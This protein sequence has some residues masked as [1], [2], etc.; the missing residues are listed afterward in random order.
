MIM[1]RFLHLFFTLIA[2]VISFE[3]FGQCPPVAGGISGADSICFGETITLTS[4][5]ASMPG[6]WVSDDITIANVTD[7]GAVSGTSAFP[8][9]VII[10]YVVASGCGS[11]SAMHTVYIKR[12]PFP[13]T[14]TGPATVCNGST[15]SLAGV[16][17]GGVW[18]SDNNT[19]AT[20][21][22]TGVVG[23]AAF[24]GGA[25]T[26]SY[27]V[28]TFSCG[29]AYTTAP[30][31]VI[32][33][34][35]P[36][37]ITGADTI[38]QL[39]FDTLRN[40][41]ATQGGSWRSK[42]GFVQF[43]SAES[44]IDTVMFKGIVAGMDTLVYTV[45]TACGTDSAMFSVTINSLPLDGYV[46]GPTEVCV[47]S[48]ITLTEVGGTPLG[49]WSTSDPAIAT[50][51]G[52]TGVVTGNSGGPVVITYSGSTACGSLPDMYPIT[53]N[54]LAN[55]VIAPSPSHVCMG[56]AVTLLNTGSYGTGTWS[57]GN[58]FI[59]TVNASTGETG[60]N[61]YGNATI[62]YITTTPGCGSD[63]ATLLFTVNPLPVP[64]IITGSDTVCSAGTTTLIDV[65]PSGSWSSLDPAIAIVSAT[66]LVTGISATLATTTIRYTVVSAT[67]G[68]VF[69]SHDITVK[70][71][72]VAGTISG[73]STI[74]RGSVISLLATIPGTWS[75]TSP[76]V[77]VNATTGAITGINV[78]AATITS[79]VT[80][81]CGSD[82]STFPVSITDVPV[83]TAISSID[84][85]CQGNTFVAT[86]GPASGSWGIHYG[87]VLP[88][89]ATPTTANV[90]AAAGGL[91]TLS[92]TAGNSCGYASVWKTIKV[93]TLPNPG[94][95]TGTDSLC[96]GNTAFMYNTTGDPGGTWNHTGTHVSISA[97]ALVTALTPGTDTVY[98]AI[99]G[100][101]GT[102]I[103]T[104]RLTVNPLPIA[105]TITGPSGV[106]IGSSITLSNST[107]T[108]GGIWT[109]GTGG[110]IT[111]GGV[112][113]G[114]TAGNVTI[115][116]E[117]TTL[118]GSLFALYTVTVNPLP[119]VAAIT[120]TSTICVGTSATLNNATT[121]GFWSCVPASVATI[122]ITTGEYHG[123][124]PGVAVV[125]YAVSNLC[126]TTT[127]TLTANVIT[128]P[129]VAAILGTATV[130]A[131]GATTLS[132]ATPGGVWSVSNTHATIS[133]SGMVTGVTAGVDTV[134]YTVT[135]ACGAVSASR[136][137]TINGVPGA[138]TIAGPSIACTGTSI[139]LTTIVPGGTW[140][141]SNGNATV[142]GGIVTGVSAGIDTIYYAV[143]NSCGSA[144]TRK[145]ITIH[146]GVVPM[147]TAS[148]SPNDTLCGAAPATYTATPVNGG[149]AP[150]IEWKRGATSIG[151]GL[152]LGDSP[153][154]GDVISCRMASNAACPTIDT[155]NSNNI[156]MHVYPIVMPVVTVT[157]SPSDTIT[158][159]GQPVTFTATLANCGSSPVYQWYE[160]GT[161][162]VGATS[163]TYSTTA[164]GN[165]AFYCI[166]ECNIPC[167]V[168]V[169][170]HSN[171]VTLYTGHVGVN[172][173]H[174][175][176]VSF[177]LYPNPNDGTFI[178]SGKMDRVNEA[179]AYEV[180][181]MMGRVVHTGYTM[182]QQASINAQVT[183][184]SHT[185][186]GQ[187]ML[188]LITANGVEVIHFTIGK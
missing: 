114:M 61:N 75:S 63:T 32:T 132:D 128:L 173:I 101:C 58:T 41:A 106:C 110:T 99:T 43:L 171:V 139:T 154:D 113:T 170:N 50:V 24:L 98:Y 120:G 97:T 27:T 74:C 151:T 12:S 91:D 148:V 38:C 108:P 179:V 174:P 65:T 16:N 20:V 172:N 47:G 23:G 78:G 142:T 188:R 67:C 160:N 30:I 164:V 107:G 62:S 178:L 76:L 59:A 64:G 42:R 89:T 138:D 136:L 184:D 29:S 21:S 105:G 92:Y 135:N 130:C 96:P 129:V 48:S 153:A 88:T 115:F 158:F 186:P 6:T 60:G 87:Y 52:L 82:Y 15:I 31:D 166:A 121:A 176:G 146:V 147:V 182:P 56:S 100:Y 14:I 26:I 141:A 35:V 122:D 81:L 83:M 80:N 131:G 8:A 111:P 86:A 125:S 187:Y 37:Y 7:A 40:H 28:S 55:A 33:L 126:G 73:V 66:G 46:T 109:C 150:F 94:Y 177:S 161:A 103:A 11:D 133:S 119:T 156:T 19:I 116:Y 127:V 134:Y 117:A 159:I 34:P 145:I 68:T 10:K 71:L 53:V 124:A 13:G 95:V 49:H 183:L 72:P 168:S 181:D 17:P 90:Y 54:S 118:C 162:I 112:F 22:S 44:G 185:A 144:T 165:D 39:S 2:L 9:S 25:T 167:A 102:T 93:L 85:I 180:I 5:G 1:R 18:S 140:T 175:S 163:A 152:T 45:F 36:G 3:S 57:S 70:P 4:F 149:T 79:T 137:V 84:S 123:V 51:N 77:L 155:V 104:H 143:T 169:S 69:T 157:V